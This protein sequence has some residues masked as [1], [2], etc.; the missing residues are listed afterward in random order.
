M[1]ENVQLA[2]VVMKQAHSGQFRNDGITPY[3]THPEKVVEILKKLNVT[4][5]A[6]LC[7]GYLHDIL[8]DTTYGEEKIKQ[9]PKMKIV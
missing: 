6:V 1:S 9:S 2:Q 4:N 8:E 5:P 7:A 3:S